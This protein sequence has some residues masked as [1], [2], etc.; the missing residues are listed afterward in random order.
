VPHEHVALHVRDCVP[1]IPHACELV[2]PDAHVPSPV[3]APYAPHAHVPLH[4]RACVPHMP[5]LALST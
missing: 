1:H 5:Q 3:H 2:A 4:T